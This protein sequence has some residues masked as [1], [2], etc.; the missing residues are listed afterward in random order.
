MRIGEHH[1]VAVTG[2]A[3]FIGSHLCR[4]LVERGATVLAIDNLVTGDRENITDLLAD[5]RFRLLELDVVDGHALEGALDGPLDAVLHLASAASVPTYLALPLETLAV[6]S[7]GTWNALACADEAG[8]RFLL[9]STS[10]IY[11][12]PVQHPQREDSWGKV[13]PIGLRSVYVEA[14]RFA[15]T[16]TMAFHRARDTDVRIA[17]IHNT[18]GPA[19]APADG[20]VVSNFLVQAMRGMPMTVHGDGSQTRSFCYVE[21]TVRGLIAL[22]ESDHVGPVN[23][24][25]PSELTILELA[26]IIADMLGTPSRITFEDLPVDDPVRRCP[27]ISLAKEVLGWKP[28]IDL[29]EGLARTCEWY[30]SRGIGPGERDG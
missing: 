15:E 29:R 24:G 14:K 23:L 6:G 16:L 30:R 12:D 17:R 27:D 21:D 25:N 19:L 7:E 2:G 1:R 5:E 28:E 3:G 26:E 22:L 9:A 8:A 10:E 13:N 4:A 20:R 18:Y 11:G